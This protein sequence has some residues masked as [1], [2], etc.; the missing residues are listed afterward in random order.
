MLDPN[1]QPAPASLV[2]APIRVDAPRRPLRIALAHD[3]LVALRGGERVLDAI[4][5]TVAADHRI[6]ALYVMFDAHTAS[7]PEVDLLRRE[8][9]RLGRLPGANRA[10]RWLLPVYPLAVRDLS[11]RLARD[12]AQEPIDLLISSS[13]SAIKALRAPDGVPHLCYCHAP[14]R[15]LWARP[16]ETSAA[17]PASLLRR[18]G[19]RLAGPSLRSWD[20]STAPRVDRFIANSRHTAAEI[21]R[22]YERDA[23]VVPPPARLDFFTPDPATP[24]RDFWLVVSALEPYKRVDLAIRAAE[25]AGARL[26]VVG[27]GSHRRTIE[28]L[29]SGRAE[30]LGQVDD[31][32]L[33]EL[34]RA[35]RCL[36]FPQ[37]EDF[38]I[39]AVEALACGCPV[40]ARA[41]GGALDIL[42]DGVTG[43]LFKQADPESIAR[44]AAEI[45][46]DCE[47]AC[48]E[49]AERFS[50][51]AFSAAMLGE[52]ETTL[53][54][55]TRR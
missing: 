24:R 37:V 35:A 7:T 25:Y 13:S 17:Q 40:V 4:A 29:A 10:R 52:I 26:T 46:R 44:A 28:R 2:S 54:E 41:R 50:M 19:L 6:S 20:R 42:T 53:R 39:V 51:A 16:D 32:R 34:Y 30:L 55:A 12:H 5:E 15:Y 47:R 48:R 49:S 36:V 14:A 23:S 9:S 31:T 27:S 45:P 3:W 43:R 38:G 11:R 1:T 22:A 18:A 21:R 33:R 8:V